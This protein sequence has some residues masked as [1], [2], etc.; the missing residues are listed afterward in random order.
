MSYRAGLEEMQRGIIDL[1]EDCVEVSDVYDPVLKAEERPGMQLVFF[2]RTISVSVGFT[3]L[4]S[5]CPDCHFSLCLDVQRAL[6]WW[7]CLA[8]KTLSRW[9]DQ[10]CHRL[11]SNATAQ[12][13]SQ[14]SQSAA[15]AKRY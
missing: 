2:N 14:G 6:R 4:I 9:P 8:R 12:Y 15:A 5:F 1:L 13:Q 10:V 3:L 11:L 7:T